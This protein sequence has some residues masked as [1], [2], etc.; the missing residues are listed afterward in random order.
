MSL[1]F[2]DLKVIF[3]AVV[4]KFKLIINPSYDPYFPLNDKLNLSPSLK[5]FDDYKYATLAMSFQKCKLKPFQWQLLARKKLSAL[6]GYANKRKLPKIVLLENEIKLTD[7]IFKRKIYLRLSTKSDIPINLVYKKPFNLDLS[8]FIF[9]AGSTSG[10]HIGYGEAKVPIDHKR[11]FIGADFAKQAA[12]KGYLAITFEM[13]GYGE[14]LER[15]LWK[16]SKSRTIDFANHLLLLGRSLMGNGATEISSVIDWLI[17]DNKLIKINKKK[18]F[19]F[20]HSSGGTLAQ[21]ASALDTRIIGTLASGS[22]GPI[23]ETIGSRGSST[24]DGIVPGFLKWFDS[25]DII[26]LI[27]PRVFIGL[28]GDKDHIFPY[29]GVSKVINKSKVIYKKMNSENKIIGIKTKG[30]HQYYCKESWLAW[31]KYINKK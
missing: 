18:I 7:S 27:A 16:K 6:T 29:K 12:E 26:S 5:T 25:S 8:V 20:G 1:K 21:F 13:A 17:S 3:Y 14:R 28:S 4:R 19:L 11:I 24:G 2:I 23:R 15:K 10:A 30:K 31:E 22:V 9:L